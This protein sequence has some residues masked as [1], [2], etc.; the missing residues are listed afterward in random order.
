MSWLDIDTKKAKFVTRKL[1]CLLCGLYHEVY[2]MI[3]CILDHYVEYR[4]I[5]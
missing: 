3:Y 2:H 1:R 5:P 4:N